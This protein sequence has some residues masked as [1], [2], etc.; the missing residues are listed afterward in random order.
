MDFCF[1]F[2]L[3]SFKSAGMSY[4]KET[5]RQ[6]V[7]GCQ[8]SKARRLGHRLYMGPAQ[9]KYNLGVLTV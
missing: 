3:L 6:L 1:I 7:F 5:N 2:Q 8:N 9:Q 4:L